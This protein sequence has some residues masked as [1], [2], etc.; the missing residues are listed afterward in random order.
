MAKTPGKRELNSEAKK[1]LIV[2]KSLELFSQYGY[3][4]I[5]INDICE[6]CKINVGTLYHHFGSK[7]GILQAIS[8]HISVASAL[9]EIDEDLVKKPI[10]AITQFFLD[11]ATRWKMLGADLTTQIFINFQKIYV[12]SNYTLKDSEAINSLSR[13]IKASQKAGCFDPAADPMTTANTIMLIGR[14]VVYDWCMQNGNYD[15]YERALEVMGLI[16][17]FVRGDAG[18]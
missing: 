13:F 2:T 1:E 16:K 5:T 14:G 10:E 12:N 3:E 6:E 17:F 4:K 7:M 18:F 11:Y 15:L 9:T 8:S